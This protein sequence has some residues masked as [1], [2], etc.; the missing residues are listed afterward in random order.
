[1]KLPEFKLERFF[2][3]YEFTAPYLLS[4]SDCE[5]MTIEEL[6]NLESDAAQ[7]FHQTWLG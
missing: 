7:K 2:A 1:M 4:A 6:L 5:A 3:K